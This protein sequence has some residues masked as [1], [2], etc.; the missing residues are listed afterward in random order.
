[1]GGGEG[2]EIVYALRNDPTLANLALNNIGEAG[3]LTRKVYQRRLPENPN[4]DYYYII[5]ETK[6]LESI[7]VEY[8]FI[9]NTKDANKLRNNLDDYVEAVV[10][11]IAEYSNVLYTPPG[12][13][14]GIYTVQKG[15]TLYRI[16]NMFNTT[17]S[18]LKRLNNL[19]SDT[20]KVGQVLLIREPIE[21]P[22]TTTIYTVQKGDSL[23]S[24]ATAFKTTVDTIKQLNNLTSNT[25]LIGQQL[26]VPASDNDN[27]EEIENYDIY[28]VVK[29]DSL[30]SIAQRYGITVDELINLNNLDNINLK[31]GDKLKVP[32]TK[33]QKTYTVQKG[34]SLWSIARENNTT[35]DEL[36]AINNLTSNLLTIGQVLTIPN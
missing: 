10:K 36:K 22:T 34:D 12:M 26:L 9:D 7:L 16:A 20:L 13:Q 5:R 17:V 3:Q 15:D 14:E 30:W 21:L 32:A 8:G 27:N 31:I 35:V 6:P 1:M 24:I 18:E 23:Y 29:G 11:A 28:E 2:A 33:G 4:Q 25:I 19:T